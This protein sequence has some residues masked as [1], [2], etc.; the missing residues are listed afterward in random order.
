MQNLGTL[1][2]SLSPSWTNAINDHGQVVGMSK[3]ASGDRRAFL[4][5][6]GTM[7]D[8]GI[9]SFDGA[10]A[11]NNRGQI[12]GQGGPGPFQSQGAFLYEDG[13]SHSTIC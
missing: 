9:S 6:N 2:G 12:V 4:Y 1:G 7:M 3:N 5:E 10:K 13:S 8:L 11:I